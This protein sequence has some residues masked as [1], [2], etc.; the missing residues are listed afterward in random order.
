MFSAVRNLTMDKTRLERSRDKFD[1]LA[2]ASLQF[3]FF[4]LLVCSPFNESSEIRRGENEN[5]I[6]I[7]KILL[8]CSRKERTKRR[9]SAKWRER[10]EKRKKRRGLL[11]GRIGF[12]DE[13]EENTKKGKIKRRLAVI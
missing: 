7:D 13:G 4:I 5:Q 12:R 1:F 10:E 6:A 8:K 9:K 2:F 3:S 11:M